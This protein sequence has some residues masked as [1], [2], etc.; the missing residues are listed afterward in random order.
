[1]DM[2]GMRETWGNFTGPF[3]AVMP[4]ESNG[5]VN[6][7]DGTGEEICTCYVNRPSHNATAIAAA[8]NLIFGEEKPESTDEQPDEQPDDEA[9]I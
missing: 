2:R 9:G 1:M 3:K 7:V 4:P 6:V 8:L 5:Y